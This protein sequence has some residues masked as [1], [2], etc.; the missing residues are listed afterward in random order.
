M[1]LVK[2]CYI[3]SPYSHTDPSVMRSRLEEAERIGAYFQEKYGYAFIHPIVTSAR[4]AA[5]NNNLQGSFKFW[6]NIDLT[7]ISA[8]DEVWVLCLDGWNA[9]IGVTAE[10]AYA[11]SPIS[12]PTYGFCN[13]YNG[14]SYTPSTIKVK[15]YDPHTERFISRETA[16]KRA[17]KRKQDAE[18]TIN[19]QETKNPATVTI[20]R[21]CT[22][23][24]LGYD[25]YDDC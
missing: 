9:S 2:K 6:E 7:F 3:A 21:I 23:R 16:L 18:I 24:D 12:M 19:K 25:E 4:L 15:Y 5:V 10:I 8:C 1:R 17:N 20:H 14:I 11:E 13:E 22:N